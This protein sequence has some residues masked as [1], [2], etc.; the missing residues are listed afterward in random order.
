MTQ[1]SHSWNSKIELLLLRLS[2]LQW[3][4]R[5][6]GN[7]AKIARISFCS[8][9]SRVRWS[10]LHPRGVIL[11]LQ[12]SPYS[13]LSFFFRR[14]RMFTDLNSLG[15]GNLHFVCLP[16]TS[17]EQFQTLLIDF[18]ILVYLK[19]PI[20]QASPILPLYSFVFSSESCLLIIIALTDFFLQNKFNFQKALF[21]EKPLHDFASESIYILL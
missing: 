10:C 8:M 1:G 2:N 5:V 16:I 17:S 21:R 13:Y 6:G 18:L 12:S 19:N 14:R 15:G 4:Q 9:I 7:L 20:W 3:L 11:D